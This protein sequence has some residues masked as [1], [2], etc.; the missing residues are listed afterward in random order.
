MRKYIF[1]IVVILLVIL[2]ILSPNIRDIAAGTAIL[3]FG[4][5]LLEDGFKYFSGSLITVAEL[6]YIQSDVL[7]EE[8]DDQDKDDKKG[9]FFEEY[10]V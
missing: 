4:V 6:L 8:D 3:M 7:L 5:M 1:L 10:A 9:D 2:F